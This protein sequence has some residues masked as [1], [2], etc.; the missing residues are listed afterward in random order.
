[1][2]ADGSDGAGRNGVGASSYLVMVVFFF[3]AEDGIRDYKVTGVQTC[4]LPISTQPACPGQSRARVQRWL[5][6]LC[7]AAGR[8]SLLQ[9]RAPGARP[10]AMLAGTQSPAP[11]RRWL[12]FR[13]EERRVGEEGRSRGLADHL[14]KKK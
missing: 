7:F 4:A 13:L 14:K 6:G 10:A 5:A 2:F 1:M 9:A 12:P 8:G 3:Q 11:C